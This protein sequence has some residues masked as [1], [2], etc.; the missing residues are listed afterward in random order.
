MATQKITVGIL[1][2]GI[3]HNTRSI[4]DVETRKI[5]E[6][7][8]QALTLAHREIESLKEQLNQQQQTKA[9]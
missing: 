5:I 9:D 2:T 8:S 6:T 4:K 7:I 1:A 3:A